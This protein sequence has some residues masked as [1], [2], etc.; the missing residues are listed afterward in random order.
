MADCINS[1][2]TMV[3]G[4]WQASGLTGCVGMRFP[5]A[6]LNPIGVKAR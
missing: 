2:G 6:I 5:V 3:L 1:S 4:R